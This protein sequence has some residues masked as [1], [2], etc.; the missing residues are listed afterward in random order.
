MKFFILLLALGLAQDPYV[1]EGNYEHTSKESAAA[2]CAGLTSGSYSLCS[3]A[4]LFQIVYSDFEGFSFPGLCYSGFT[5]D[6]GGEYQEGWFMSDPNACGA[7]TGWRGWKPASGLG[8]HCC[9]DKVLGITPQTCDTVS[10]PDG[11]ILLDN[12]NLIFCPTGTCDEEI[13]CKEWEPAQNYKQIGGYDYPTWQEAEVA[14]TTAHEDY[15]LCNQYQI[16]SLAQ[17]G[18]QM[19]SS[20][21]HLDSLDSNG[22]AVYQRGWYVNG[23]WAAAGNCGGNEGWRYW[24]PSDGAGSAHCC[25]PS[26]H[27]SGYSA[28]GAKTASDFK[29]KGVDYCASTRY[30]P[31]VCT[32]EQVHKISELENRAICTSGL[33]FSTLEDQEAENDN[34]ALGW[35][36]GTDVC[37]ST[38]WRGWSP[39]E[40][41]VHCCA[42][43]APEYVY[44]VLAW[45]YMPEVYGSGYANAAAAAN[46][47]TG[48]GYDQ[49]CT[50]EQVVHIGT[51]LQTDLCIVG[52]V[53]NSDKAGYYRTSGTCGLPD[54]WNDQWQPSTPVAFCC[55]ADVP[56]ISLAPAVLDPYVGPTWDYSFTSSDSAEGE[57]NS[58]QGYSLCTQ[59]QLYTIAYIG[60]ERSDGTTQTASS[61]CRY[62]WLKNDIKGWYQATEGAC[63]A[64]GWRTL[65]SN[66]AHAHCCL[67][68]APAALDPTASPTAPPPDAFVQVTSG[69]TLSSVEAARDAC[70]N[71]YADYQLCSS[72]QVIEVAMNGAA[73][74]DVFLP[75]DARTDLCHSAWL[76]TDRA[77]C[78]DPVTRGW[79]I[80][81]AKCGGPNT[82][83][84]W[85]PND[86]EGQ[87]ISGAF[88]CAP[89]VPEYTDAADILGCPVEESTSA[90]ETT[91]TAP[92]TTTTTTSTGQPDP[93]TEIPDDVVV[94]LGIDTSLLRFIGNEYYFFDGNHFVGTCVGYGAANTACDNR[95]VVCGGILKIDF[96]TYENQAALLEE[97]LAETDNKHA[98]CPPSD[99]VSTN[100]YDPEGFEAVVDYCLYDGCYYMNGM[101]TC[102]CSETNAATELQTLWEDVFELSKC[103]DTRPFDEVMQDQLFITDK[104]IDDLEDQIN[105]IPD[106]NQ[107]LSDAED[108]LNEIWQNFQDE[109]T[110]ILN[111]ASAD[112]NDAGN[113]DV[114]AQLEQV[115]T[116]LD[117]LSNSG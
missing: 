67:D 102:V 40:P 92:I 100:V 68:F 111:A 93:L 88:C 50:L 18:T 27:N 43:Y 53:S 24:A 4:Q 46:A 51:N 82:F 54:V 112:A 91:T 98:R 11:K 22:D 74:S 48:R 12:S 41:S 37:G 108:D 14:C 87:P 113:T 23:D 19:C 44:E 59:E 15:V 9:L 57:C 66:N 52:W 83:K 5:S 79:Y 106:I 25:T 42:T 29:T 39:A 7:Q 117:N 77:T 60:V 21:W 86:D 109:I 107:Q 56:E 36:Q 72:A 116:D 35:W 81:E 95:A 16:E 55:Q 97:A 6:E 94:A 76:E 38:G 89:T 104:M 115:I 62:G 3:S 84:T 75:V 105:N 32:T 99:C 30:T 34:T 80:V 69:Y 63:G 8:A 49:L 58:G 45:E 70:T 33:C 71:A 78:A 101:E 96:G 114:A 17:S 47:C 90:P 2:V 1:S 13:C 20:G 61:I 64:T 65:D 110:A 28:I 31:D 10:C 26:Y 73:G 103:E 85:G